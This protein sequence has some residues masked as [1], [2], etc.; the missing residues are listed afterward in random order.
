MSASSTPIERDRHMLAI[1]H[2]CSQS[3]CNLVDFLPFKCQHCSLQFCGEHFLPQRHSCPKYDEFQHNRVAPDC[4]LCGEPVAIPP[5]EDP[6][7]RMERHLSQ[8]CTVMT[9]KT[10]QSK[11]PRCARAMCNK[12]LYAP[13]KC[14]K[15]KLEFCPTHRFPATH[16]CSSIGS[17][18]KP[19]L[20][21]PIVRSNIPKPSVSAS[22]VA[23]AGKNAIASAKESMAAAKA[24]TTSAAKAASLPGPFNKT[25]R[26]GKQ[27]RESQRK[28]MQERARKG[29]LSEQEKVILAELE[30]ER[31]S[32]GRGNSGNGK[33]CIV[34]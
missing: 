16:N 8:E 18:S 32:R 5:G 21:K 30:A 9:G 28:A 12:V 4:P 6:N 14:D 17:T 26:R 33:E 31:V 34:M 20:P 7:I 29:L 25:D 10:K 1:G 3:T 24:S 23:Q 2:Q 27:E 22:Q 19:A 15:C 13:I 11:T